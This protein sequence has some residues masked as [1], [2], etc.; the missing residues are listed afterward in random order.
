MGIDIAAIGIEYRTA[1]LEKG[2]RALRDNEKQA[3][4][5]ADAADGLTASIK[6]Q[7]KSSLDHVH[8]SERLIA[9]LKRQAET[10]GMTEAQ[11]RRYEIAQMRGTAAQQKAVAHYVKHIEAVEALT[12]AKRSATIAV[13]SFAAAVPAVAGA[14]AAL[15]KSQINAIDRFNDLNDATGASIENISALDRVARQNGS[16]FDTVS[17]VLVK[18][19]SVLSK[20]DEDSDNAARVLKA[21]GLNAEELKRIDPAE[22]LHRTA[23]ALSR[24][25]DDGNKARA[26]QILF[27]RSIADVAPFMRDLSEQTKLMGVVSTQAARDAEAMNKAL[28]EMRA[29]TQDLVRAI[30]LGLAPAISSLSD[31]FIVGTKHA[32][33]F[34]DAILTFGTLNPFR[35]QAAN[36]QALR[37]ELVQL[38][39]ARDRYLRSGSDTRGIDDAIRQSERQLDYL[40]E[41]QARQVLRSSSS[42]DASDAVSRRLGLRTAPSLEIPGKPKSGLG[43]VRDPFAEATRYFEN[44]QRQ[45]DKTRELTVEEQT[46]AEIR[47]GRIGKVNA[48]LKEQLLST[49]RLIDLQRELDREQKARMEAGRERAIAEGDA[50]NRANEDYQQLMQRLLDGGP[51][52]QLEK[53]RQ[54]MLMLTDALNAGAISVAQYEDA[55]RGYLGITEKAFHEMDD[56]A[57]R[58]AQNIQDSIGQGL[59]DILEGNYK[60]IGDSFVKMVNRMVAEAAAANLSRYLFGSMVSGGSGFGA[61]GS[62]VGTIAGAFGGTG[63][64]AAIASSMGGDSLQNMLNLTGGFGTMSANGNAFG[65]SGVI[66]FANGGVVDKPTFFQF[67]RGTGV[68]GEAGPEAVMP[69]KRGADGK[70]GVAGGGNTVNVNVNQSFAVGTSRE[71][72]NQAAAAARRALERAGRNL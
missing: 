2:T 6:R 38:G 10:F 52:A 46:L 12:N 13:T 50:V 70:L 47:S 45:L 8:E 54:T 44:L 28:F 31:E 40:K 23:V 56:F 39:A 42:M 7:S 35:T 64:Q 26:A 24:F 11:I 58:A 1:E 63:A 66:P 59:V 57:K 37:E 41:L 20:T 61:L 9:K 49:S 68:M 29:N 71:T 53:Q 32:N 43:G 21:L 22:S 15:A 33:G 36:M 67:S 69:L 3:N 30:S 60:N 27:G 51:A 19:N 18:F 62:L 72:I 25:A 16:S 4:K 5:T 17:A 55:V 65:P 14:F 34:F 48:L